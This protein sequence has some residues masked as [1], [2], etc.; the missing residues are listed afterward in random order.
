MMPDLEAGYRTGSTGTADGAGKAASPTTRATGAG[1]DMSGAPSISLPK[2]GGAIRGIGEK[3][4][5]NPVTGTGSMSVPIATSPGRSGFG[6]Q[7]ALSYDSGGGNGPFGFGWSLSLPQITRKTDKGLPQYND[8]AES[9]VF[10]LSGSEDL[11][12][13]LDPDGSRFEDTS[14]AAGYTIHRFRPRIEGL[15]ARIERWTRSDGDVHWRSITRDNV[16]T[17]YGTDE[18]S[19]IADPVDPGRIFT[20]LICETRDDRGNA[21]IYEYKPEDGAGVDLT[22]VHERNRGDRDDPR[23]AANHYIK[24]IRYGNRT[25]LLDSAGH[26]PRFLS[27]EDIQDVGWMFEVVFDYDDHDAEAP[28]PD[29]TGEWPVRQDPFSSYRAGFE[30]RTCRLCQRV[31]MFHHFPGE[32][33]VGNDC[34]VRSTDFTYSHE[35]DP[36][37]ARNPVYTFLRAVTQTGYKRQNGEYLKRSLPPVE[38]QYAQPVVQ[39]VVQEVDAESLENLPIGLD[40]AAYQWT[41]LHGEGIPGILT[42]QGGAW[43]YKRNLSPLNGKTDHGVAYTEAKFAPV[44]AVAVQPSLALADGAQ[45]MDLAGDG[46]PDLVVLDGPMPGLY[47]HDGEEGW[48]PYRPFSARLNRDT[49][50]PNLRFVDLDGDGHADVLITEDD[51]FVWHPSLAEEGFGPARRVHQALDEEK[52]P[53]LVFEDGEQSV[54]LADLSGDGLTDVVRIRNGEVCYW[55]N[56]G[57]G[58]FGAK[59]T[60]D[61]APRCDHPDHFEQS[62]VRL[63]DIDG[64][65]TTDIIYLHREGVRLYFNQSGN[66]WSEPQPLRVFPRVDDLV[67]I[68]PVDLLGNGTA[69]LVW[70]SPLPGDAGRQMQYVDLMGG[71]KPH[72]LV[73]TINNLGAETRVHYAPSTKFYLQDKRE[74][75]PWITRL[76][77]PVH[78]VERVETHD[79]ISRNRFVTRY[80]YHHGYFD[81]EER[82]FRGFGMVEQWDTE[83]FSA[84]SGDGAPPDATNLDAASHVPPVRTRTWFHTGAWLDR[85][86]VS[87]LFEA[88]YYREP[89]LSEEE[90]RSLLLPD[91]TLPPGLTLDEEREACRALKGM[92]LRQEVYA[93]DAPPGSSPALAQRAATPYSVVE[94]DFTIRVLQPRAGNRPAVFFIH[95]REAIT[96][97][98]ERNPADPRTQHALTLEV[99]GFGNVLRSA[100]VGYGRRFD[101]PDV[102]LAP[103]DRAKQRLIHITCTENSFTDPIDGAD[104]YRTPLPAETRTYEL[105]RA[106]Q[107]KSGS[108]V[109]DLYR[110]DDLLEHV[111]QS[112]D[113]NH[114]I[115]Y[116]DLQFV[117]AKQAAAGNPAEKTRYFRRLIERVRTLYRPDDL[118]EAAGDPLALLPLGT[119]ESLAVPGE[120]YKLAFTLGLLAQV[121]QRESQ[122]LLPN[123]AD[124]VGGQGADQGAYVVSQDLK[125]DGVFPDTDADDHWWIPSGRAFYSPD[126]NDAAAQE[127]AHAR[128]H[129]FLPHRF[130]G[131]FGHTTTVTYD[132]YDLL[133]LETED[134][135]GNRVSVGA[136][137][138]D[139]NRVDNANDYR[140][141]QPTLICDPNRNRSE[142]VFDVLGLVAGMA[143]RG[144]LEET[145]GDSL[146]V[147]EA[148]LTQAQIDAFFDSLDPHD[149]A[150]DLLG[151][152]TTRIVYDV[153]R[154]HRTGDPLQPPFAAT[155]ARES[156]VSDPVPDGGLRTQVSFSYSDGFGREIQRKI[157][158]EA[159]PLEKG[160]PIV[161]PRWV[162]SGWTIFNNKGHPVRQYEPFFSTLLEIRHQFEFA[163]KEGVS[164]VLFYDPVGRVVATLHPNHSWE[165][166]VFDPWRQETWDVNDT[167][168]VADPRDD[169]DVGDF[170]R[171]LPEDEY[172]PSWHTLRTDTAQALDRWPE[173]DPQN[174][175]PLP[176]NAAIRA[177]EKDAAEKAAVH[178]E[179]PSATHLDALGR[180]FL[181]IAH[182]RLRDGDNAVDEKYETR[183]ELDIEGNTRAV[184]DH[185]GR[186]V[187]R[188]DYDLLGTVIHTTSMDA[189]ERWML[190][191]VAGKPIRAWDSRG[192]TFRTT[193]DELRRTT[194]LYVQPQGET[195]LLAGRTVY[196][197]THPEAAD[198]NLRVSAFQQ[199]DGAGVATSDRYDFKGNLLSSSRRLC[200]EYKQRMDWSALANV[201][202]VQEIANA[203]EPL[204]EP[205]VLTT[206]TTYDAL[207]RPVSLITPDGS[208]TLPTY[209]QANLLEQVTVRLLGA[210]TATPFVNDIDYDAKGQR[211]RIEYGSEVVTEY[212]YDD[213]TFRLVH[214]NTTRPAGLN[215]RAS[216]LFNDPAVVQDL[217]YVYDPAG[218]ITRIED[219]ALRTVF[220]DGEKVDPICSY[221]Y[222]AL[223]RLIE[224]TGRE[225]IGQMA[226]DFNPPDGNYRDH[227][228]AGHHAH[229]S[230][231]QALRN[232]TERYRY[233][234]VGNILAMIHHASG[235]SW[236]RHY[237]YATDSNRLLSTSLPGDPDDG[238]YSAKYE[239]D[240]HGN[241]TAM[242]HLPEIRWDFADRMQQVDLGGGG[243]VYFVY[244]AAGQRIRKVHEHPGSTTEERIYLDG[245]E[246]YRKRNGSGLASER[247]TLHVMDYT[248]RIALVETKTLDGGV[249]LSSPTPV[250]RYQLSNHLG[251]ACLEINDE[252][253][254]IS[255]EEYHPYGTTSFHAGPSGAEVSLKRYRSTGKERDEETGLYYHGARYHTPWLGRWTAADPSGLIDGPNLYMHVRGSPVG[256]SDPSG[257]TGWKPG[258]PHELGIEAVGEGF[259]LARPARPERV[260][261]GDPEQPTPTQRMGRD[262]ARRQRISRWQVEAAADRPFRVEQRH[263]RSEVSA[264]TRPK[265]GAYEA[266]DPDPEYRSSGI[267]GAG[268]ADAAVRYEPFEVPVRE[269]PPMS[270]E[271]KLILAVSIAYVFV[272]AAVAADVAY[273]SLATRAVLAEEAAS[274]LVVDEAVIANRAAWAELTAGKPP[275][276]RVFTIGDDLTGVSE[277]TIIEHGVARDVVAMSAGTTGAESVAVSGVGRVGP[278]VLAELLSQSGWR[279]GHLRLIAC[280]T[281]TCNPQGIVLGEQLSIALGEQGLPTVVAA[282]RGLV[283]VGS[284]LWG[285]R[286]PVIVRGPGAGAEGV[287]AFTYFGP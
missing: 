182:N 236:T 50:D 101:A 138:A 82:E 78:V 180:P 226:H 128:Q 215:G 195:E 79:H 252:G 150:P 38:F 248:R 42:E 3:F 46:Q 228:F 25:S 277:L 151:T 191:D 72:L 246:V 264:V 81:G 83:T 158:A 162:G 125:A 209:N 240:A 210:A 223:Y 98:Y 203:S 137:D 193:Y 44:E 199:Y 47:E 85:E 283:M 156:H 237:A 176:E 271:E 143:V 130:R 59:V 286:A 56:L 287:E 139:G 111:V 5:A 18:N 23:R 116:E 241:M 123:P 41:D 253:G 112:G 118:G 36:D 109:P 102:E 216:Q 173:T 242:P 77:F 258:D 187:M 103:D 68:V 247:Q 200:F 238:P 69:C 86:H 135:L 154:Y 212:E 94:Q 120:S 152:A 35:Q 49:R 74:G 276:S 66:G 196:G 254:L 233:D 220:H 201:A 92:M 58:R 17:L 175:T 15:F 149:L 274:A 34:L 198:R 40:G 280:G 80:A 28:T 281:G 230:D 231:L 55:P 63:A 211:E 93:D 11:V 12:P 194:Q 275:A 57:Y 61:H 53:R 244:D 197:E 188:Y 91:T 262:A 33:G 7:L 227:P 178:A 2:G 43:F 105:R 205:E 126:P 29:D 245:Y 114:D 60:M 190:S 166:V 97:Q 153:G 6:P 54:H 269:S 221:T 272:S 229:P 161:D 219:S 147:F 250:I 9:D 282:P 157:Q 75:R 249:A 113:G 64:S 30:V 88:E 10:I 104:I 37:D 202:D 124:V 90:F 132:A 106:E 19:R 251:S 122:P 51:A 62:R 96:Y 27:T 214:L 110:F 168:L 127:L 32:A 170:F 89:G 234:P 278:N 285:T 8:A 108:G 131:P 259:L 16:L 141:L 255:L 265:T 146:D 263:G 4:A 174:G 84:L 136:R 235:G 71:T 99:D 24:R 217:R 261:V 184:L 119:V 67:S 70:S 192:H 145:L 163:R 167:V 129:F 160:G 45:F 159:G 26:R 65:G 268:G 142:V 186:A 21:V 133:L 185:F 232:Y 48:Q 144:K 284:E 239:H 206:S 73:R 134:P 279:G 267:E 179:T 76:P 87:R 100:A 213:E 155:L 181:G 224:A 52:G 140:V 189:G 22:R 95:P 31:L 208:E 1:T 115:P 14:S 13:L 260:R 117:E 20:W 177:A 204:L 273:G 107:E 266:G 148:D 183:T 172:L 171:R 256:L 243:A 207:N 270:S 257:R 39:D 225:H 165:K 121:Y 222:D 164:P 218:N 169:P